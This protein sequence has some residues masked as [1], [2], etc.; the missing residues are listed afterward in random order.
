MVQARFADRNA[1]LSDKRFRIALASLVA[2]TKEIAISKPFDSRREYVG[3]PDE[4][5]WVREA[6]KSRGAK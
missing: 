2:K 6:K 1:D 3:A 5:A 4:I